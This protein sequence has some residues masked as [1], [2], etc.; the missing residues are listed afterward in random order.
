M[1][2]LSLY[3]SF[4]LKN[5]TNFSTKENNILLKGIRHNPSAVAFEI[6]KENPDVLYLPWSTTPFLSRVKQKIP[7]ILDYV[8]AGLFEEYATKGYIP[9]TLLQMKLKSFH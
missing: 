1:V 3:E 8:G 9:T 5:K 6:E 4:H 7:T 2:I